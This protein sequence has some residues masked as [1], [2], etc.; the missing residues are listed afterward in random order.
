MAVDIRSVAP[1]HPHRRHDMT[2]TTVRQFTATEKTVSAALLA[3]WQAAD[4]RDD[5]ETARRV[6]A[7]LDELYLPWVSIDAR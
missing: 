6:K 3:A 4:E 5:D 7:A 1:C 2:A